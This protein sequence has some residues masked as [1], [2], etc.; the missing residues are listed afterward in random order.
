MEIDNAREAF[1]TAGLKV[2][3]AMCDAGALLFVMFVIIASLLGVWHAVLA[4]VLLLIFY[5][6]FIRDGS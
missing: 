1:K 5:L 2:I 4:F 3:D 6:D